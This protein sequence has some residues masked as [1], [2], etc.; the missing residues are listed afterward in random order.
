MF[1]GMYYFE[2]DLDFAIIKFVG[3]GLCCEVGRGFEGAG[4]HVNNERGSNQVGI[5]FLG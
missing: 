1:Q 2:V 4:G 5:C 3:F